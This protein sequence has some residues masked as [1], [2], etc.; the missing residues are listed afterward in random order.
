MKGFLVS[1][2]IFVAALYFSVTSDPISMCD[3]GAPWRINQECLALVGYGAVKWFALSALMVFNAVT[4]AAWA[5]R[6]IAESRQ[7]EME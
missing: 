3:L 4:A 5:I 6:M 1:S 2:I 7:R